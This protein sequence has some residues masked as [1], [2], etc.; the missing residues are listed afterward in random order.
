MD[1]GGDSMKTIRFVILTVMAGVAAHADF[2][3]ITVTKSPAGETTTKHYI[4]GQKLITD[5][6]TSLTIMDLE[7]QTMTT[8]NKT[9]KTYTV[10][11]FSDLG[12]PP[13]LPRPS[14]ASMKTSKRPASI[15]IS[16]VSTRKSW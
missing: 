7:A 6:P 12:N 15:R 16:M 14:P 4:K 2:S 10:R 8:V 13:Q 11:P 9:Q 1:F 3:Y 5:S